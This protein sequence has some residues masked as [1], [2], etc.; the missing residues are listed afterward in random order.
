MLKVVLLVPG[1]LCAAVARFSQTASDYQHDREPMGDFAHFTYSNFTL[2]LLWLTEKIKIASPTH[3]L[4]VLHF[5]ANKKNPSMMTALP[6]IAI[7]KI[8]QWRSHP[9]AV[10]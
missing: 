6:L 4:L 8:W 7:C 2:R 1:L 5:G 9:L 10:P 3:R